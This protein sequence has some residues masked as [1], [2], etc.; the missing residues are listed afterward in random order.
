MLSEAMKR[1]AVMKPYLASQ[2]LYLEPFLVLRL[3]GTAE[4]LIT[5]GDKASVREPAMLVDTRNDL[6]GIRDHLHSNIELEFHVQ[7]PT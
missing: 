1:T 6:S 3:A 5:R 4:V 7:L 2:Q